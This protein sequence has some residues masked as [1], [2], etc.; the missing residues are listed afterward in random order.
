MGGGWGSCRRWRTHPHPIAPPEGLLRLGARDRLLPLI[1][2]QSHGTRVFAKVYSSGAA[3][4]WNTDFVVQASSLARRISTSMPSGS[5]GRSVSRP[6]RL[7]SCMKC[8]RLDR[9][10]YPSNI[11]DTKKMPLLTQIQ[12][13]RAARFGNLQGEVVFPACRGPSRHT[14]GASRRAWVNGPGRYL[15]MHRSGRRAARL[16]QQLVSSSLTWVNIMIASPWYAWC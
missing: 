5:A 9:M 12:M 7:W 14:A 15:G 2:C 1:L 16:L 11:L 10:S 4:S 13:E 3:K 8:S 6:R